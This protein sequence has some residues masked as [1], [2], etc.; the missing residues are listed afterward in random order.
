MTVSVNSIAILAPGS[1]IL[2]ANGDP[3]SDG[4][5][6]F[7]EAGTSDPK[8]VYSD[9]ELQTSL[10]TIVYTDS[11]GYPVTT[12]GGSTKTAIF[13]GTGLY[14]IIITDSDDATIVSHDNQAGAIDT[15]SFSVEFAKS[16]EPVISLTSSR[17]AL[18]TDY[19][20]TI[21]ANST[22]GSITYS[23]PAAADAESHRIRVRHSGTAGTVSIVAS[24]SET[25]DGPQG[26]N[27]AYQLTIFGDE[28]QLIST[29]AGWVAFANYIADGTI[30]TQQLSSA[31]SGAFVQTGSIIPWPHATVP[32]GYLHCDGS[33]VSRTT[34]SDL[35]AVIS[36]DYGPGDGSTTFNLPDY[37]GETLRGFDDGSGNDP[38]AATRTDRGDGTTGDNVGTKQG[39][40]IA[41]HTHGVGTLAGT[42]DEYEHNHNYGNSGQATGSGGGTNVKDAD[43]SGS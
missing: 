6:K 18:T 7:F 32:T 38:D 2:D 13:I 5:L 14:K 30:T 40:A 42:T 23:L 28:V 33:A 4:R 35:F 19:G 20:K 9:C 34:Y 37:R 1:R 29:G 21:L 43:N 39:S 3:V 24:G 16:L 25:I 10:G 31:I 26:S 41:S 22:A 36:D 27:A 15:S 11:G 17:A 12:Q 8:T